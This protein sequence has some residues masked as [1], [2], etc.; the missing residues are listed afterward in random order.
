MFFNRYSTQLVHSFKRHL[1]TRLARFCTSF[2]KNNSLHK[3]TLTM[4]KLKP[5]TYPKRIM[6]QYATLHSKFN[7]WL[8]KAGVMRM[9]LL[10]ISNVMKFLQKVFAKTSKT[11][12][13]KTSK[14][15]FYC[16][17]TFY[18]FSYTSKTC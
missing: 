15:H 18:S 3:R 14:T 1:S 16:F 17:R 10:L 2:Q 8:K 9:H 4:L 6:K 11:L 7:S 13:K 5:L 12:Q